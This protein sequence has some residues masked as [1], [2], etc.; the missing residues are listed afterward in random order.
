MNTVDLRAARLEQALQKLLKASTPFA[1]HDW[2]DAELE[3]DNCQLATHSGTVTVGDWRKLRLAV[4]EAASLSS[5]LGT[6]S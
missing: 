3:D 6:A 2:M 1:A 5:T 4:Q